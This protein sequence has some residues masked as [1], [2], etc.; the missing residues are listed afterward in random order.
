MSVERAKTIEWDGNVLSGWITINGKLFSAG[1]PPL[2]SL[3]LR[4]DQLAQP[5]LDLE[6]PGLLADPLF[7]PN[8]TLG[9]TASS[10]LGQGGNYHGV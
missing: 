9:R 3:L 1:R 5:T 8:A 7:G 10:M 2:A 6:I 4:R